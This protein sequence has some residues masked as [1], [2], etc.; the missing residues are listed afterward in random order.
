MSEPLRWGVLSTARINELVLAGA[1]ACEQVEVLAVA[2]RDG[3][4][5]AA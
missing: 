3:A 1:R 2:S 4:S 5:A